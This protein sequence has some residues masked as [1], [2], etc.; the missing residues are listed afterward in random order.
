V[1]SQNKYQESVWQASVS[2]DNA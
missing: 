2:V 1:G